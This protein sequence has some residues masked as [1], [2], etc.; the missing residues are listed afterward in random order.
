MAFAR[1]VGLFLATNFL[2]LTLINALM[3]A[4]GLNPSTYLGLSAVCLAY[5]MIGS[6]ISLSMSKFMAKRSMGLQMLDPETEADPRLREIVQSVHRYASAAG[7]RTMPEVAVYDSPELNAFATGPSKNNSLVAVST[8]LLGSMSKDEVEGVLG[9]EVAHIANGD[10][11]TMTL[12]QG[13]INAFV[14]FLARIIASAVARGSDNRGGGMAY[15][16]ISMALQMVFGVLGSVVVAWFS[17]WREF[18]A[19]EGGAEYAGRHKM[20]AALKK[21]ASHTGVADPRQ[22]KAYASMKI[23]AGGLKSLMSSHPPLEKRIYALQQG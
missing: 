8:G 23:S 13:V 18:R 7:L 21:L 5:G 12:L 3:L 17:R 9:H 14:L 1:R 16:G 22:P 6:F 19:D 2:I 10:M 20:I 15:F 4:F 11:V